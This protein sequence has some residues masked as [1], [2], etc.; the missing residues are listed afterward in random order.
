[1]PGSGLTGVGADCGRSGNGYRT[2]VTIRMVPMQLEV[3]GT[4]R[5]ATGAMRRIVFCAK[6]RHVVGCGGAKLDEGGSTDRE[7]GE[8]PCSTLKQLDSKKRSCRTVAL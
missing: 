7:S 1:M 5:P 4:R 6:L 2:E 8:H 3:R